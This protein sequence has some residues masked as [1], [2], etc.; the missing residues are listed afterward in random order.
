MPAAANLAMIWPEWR[1]RSSWH[2]RRPTVSRACQA[3]CEHGS[4][5]RS[6][7]ICGTSLRRSAGAASSGCGP[8]AN[9]ST[10]CGSGTSGCSMTLQRRPSKSSRSSRRR[11]RRTGSKRGVLETRAVGLA[12]V[13]DDLSKYLRL[14]AEREIVI[15]RHGRPAGVLIGFASEDEWLDYRLEHDPEFLRRIAEARAAIRQGHGVSLEDID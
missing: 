14:A 3:T 1:S 13:K 8:S 7:D 12:R 9:L 10:D 4:R 2:Q 11:K 5:M 6:N 15:T